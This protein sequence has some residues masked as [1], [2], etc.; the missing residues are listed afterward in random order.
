MSKTGRSFLV[1]SLIAILLAGAIG[2]NGGGGGADGGGGDAA[3]HIWFDVYGNPCDG[4]FPKP[5]CNFYSDGSKIM[6]HEDPW[7]RWYPL[8]HDKEWL[9]DGAWWYIDSYGTMRCYFGKAWESPDYIIYDEWGY[10]LNSTNPDDETRDSITQLAQ[11]EGAMMK[12]AGK[13]FAEAHGLTE[14]VG[15][16]FAT[17]TNRWATLPVKLNRARTDEDLA[18]FSKALL[19]IELGQAEIAVKGAFAGDNSAVQELS[20][21][22]AQHWQTTP[23]NA[24]RILKGWLSK[25]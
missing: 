9:E 2:C 10:A 13:A 14:D 3:M 21:D 4:A 19:G 17:V 5:G 16:R 24:V 6:D 25:K 23:E 1:L 22:I 7:F 20:G 18:A 11:Q 8:S 12:K 15:I